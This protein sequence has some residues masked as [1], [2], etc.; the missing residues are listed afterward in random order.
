MLFLS[1]PETCFSFLSNFVKMLSYV[2][3]S[4]E[5]DSYEIL[6]EEY[7]GFYGNLRHCSLAELLDSSFVAC[8]VIISKIL[9]KFFYVSCHRHGRVIICHF[10]RPCQRL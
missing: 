9:N 8:N 2:N 7:C 3:L 1:L 10:V 4:L 5:T 6:P